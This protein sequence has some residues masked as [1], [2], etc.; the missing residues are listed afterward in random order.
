MAKYFT[1][2][3]SLTLAP[4]KVSLNVSW[5]LFDSQ[6]RSLAIYQAYDM[7]VEEDKYPPSHDR[8]WVK[9]N[10]KSLF[11]SPY[12]SCKQLTRKSCKCAT[13]FLVGLCNPTVSCNTY[14]KLCNGYL[15]GKDWSAR[16]TSVPNMDS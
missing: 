6:G 8:R 7:M 5:E 15:G 9:S 14:E 4:Q 3:K 1:P 16:L 11:R 2:C 13:E 12:W 10:F